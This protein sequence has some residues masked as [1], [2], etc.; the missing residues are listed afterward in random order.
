MAGVLVRG[1]MP[2]DGVLPSGHVTPVGIVRRQS[3]GW[4]QCT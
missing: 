1:G 4:P 2:V 3:R